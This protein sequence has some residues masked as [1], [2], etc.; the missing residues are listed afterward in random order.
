MII[1]WKKT[2]SVEGVKE[3]GLPLTFTNTDYSVFLTTFEPTGSSNKY[4]YVPK[5]REKNKEKITVYQDGA[6]Y[7]LVLGY[8]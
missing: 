7:I 4:V 3:I 1:Q 5:L 6:L 2:D 8:Y